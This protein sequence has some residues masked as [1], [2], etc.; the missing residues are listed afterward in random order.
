MRIINAGFSVFN[1]YIAE[2]LHFVV[3]YVVERERER[4]EE[5]RKRRETE[6]EVN[7]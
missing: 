2:C 7:L 3:C 1:F 6:K 5:R 4:K